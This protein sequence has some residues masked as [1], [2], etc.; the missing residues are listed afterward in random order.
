[1]LVTALVCAP[2]AVLVFVLVAHHEPW[3]DEAQAWQLAR[4]IA[5][6]ALVAR[7]IHYEMTPPVWH[8]LLRGEAAL[9]IGY[10]GMHWI[11]ACVGVIAVGIL[12][13]FAPFPLWMRVSLPFTYF[14]AYQYPVVARS[15]SLCPLLLFGLAALWSRREQQPWPVLA[16]LLLL[17]N[18]CVHGLVIAAG[19]AIAILWELRP[20]RGRT[21]R[22]GRFALMAGLFAVGFGF[23]AW[24]CRPPPDA[25]W[26]V[27]VQTWSQHL[28]RQ[29]AVVKLSPMQHA[30]LVTRIALHGRKAA[31]MGALYSGIA[32]PARLVELL[33]PLLLLVLYRRR[34][35]RYGWPI[36][37]LAFIGTFTRF[38]PYHAGLMWLLALFLL[39]VSWPEREDWLH[40]ALVA[41]FAVAIV[42]QIRWTFHV[43]RREIAEPYAPTLAALPV[44]RGYLAEGRT[45][46][47]SA[48]VGTDGH[49]P[50][51]FFAVA[52]EP[53]FAAQPFA[54]WSARFWPWPGMPG[55]QELYL[56]DTEA[57]RT[58]VL[59]VEN[60]GL[61]TAEEARLESLGY[62]RTQRV[63]GMNIYPP[64]FFA[65]DPL[66]YSF[67]EPAAGSTEGGSASASGPR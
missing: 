27:A 2:L 30:V 33:W 51:G 4:S 16:G 67:Y 12:V 5:P 25:P 10:A 11:T 31:L 36:A 35:L 61:K 23:A 46:E 54:N 7:W 52:M 32:A 48:Q 47:V 22:F 38:S 59:A 37:L 65:D 41:M 19:L 13:A 55:E 39:W 20:G 9:G 42:I 63:C 1:V 44:L 24:C 29:G 56:A 53:Y 21:W 6:P 50:P 49:T 45:V 8:L 17:A 57:R 28:G 14:L 15:Y 34:M 58:V 18:T 40:L 3:A 43:V 62:A 64:N 66:C 26:V 60:G